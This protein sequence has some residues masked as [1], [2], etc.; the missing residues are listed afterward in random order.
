MVIKM[1][2]KVWSKFSCEHLW[3]YDNFREQVGATLYNYE[4]NGNIIKSITYEV[5][6]KIAQS[7]FDEYNF[8][9]VIINL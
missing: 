6:T 2:Y 8:N 1:L 9:Y 5:D 7:V 3:A 4:L